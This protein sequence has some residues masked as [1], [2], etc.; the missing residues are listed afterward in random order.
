MSNRRSV[1]L[2]RVMF[3][4]TVNGSKH[5]HRPRNEASL[6]LEAAKPRVNCPNE[7]VAKRL[8]LNYNPSK[9]PLKVFTNVS[10]LQ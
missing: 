4:L 10:Y 5:K 8:R 9:C 6:G 1:L 3:Q 2:I 7:N